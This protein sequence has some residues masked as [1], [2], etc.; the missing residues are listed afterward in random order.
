[1]KLIKYL[2]ILLFISIN[3]YSE[4]FIIHIVG[5]KETLWSISKK[6]NVP[7]DEIIK[8]NNLTDSSKLT[9][10]TQLKIPD[11]TS[12]PPVELIKETRTMDLTDDMTDKY[13]SYVFKK[14]DSV[15]QISRKY[16]I[17][18][19]ELMEL[20]NIKDAKNIKDGTEL[21]IEKISNDNQF[22][23]EKSSQIEFDTY[24][25]KE[26]ETLYAISR[27]FDITVDE[28][29]KIN[30]ITNV[31]KIKSGIVLKISKKISKVSVNEN[32][33]VN[34]E[35]VPAK[36]ITYTIKEKE[37]LWSMSKKFN[38]SVEKI[39]EIN[40]IKSTKSIKKGSVLKIPASVNYLDYNLP[41]DGMIKSFSS[42]HFKGIHIYTDEDNDKRNILAVN[43][44]NVS[45]VDNVPGFG[46][47][48]FIR[49]NDDYISTYSGFEVIYV[50]Q[51]DKVKINQLIGK[52]GSLSRHDKF[53][54][55]FS[56]Q[57]KGNSLE[58]DQNNKKFIKNFY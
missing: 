35:N 27:K 7:L 16:G 31:S 2:I 14:G 9:S 54:I 57:Y 37:T 4:D 53:G 44:G 21:K 41:A 51:G 5:E 3:I 48:I 39:C 25:I 49:H 52:A 23:I 42:M 18:L 33:P 19:N 34:K 22:K 11:K 1:M 15:W 20:N 32:I 12:K 45:Y 26:K 28:I 56:I 40:S 29:C 58:F 10:G 8:L 17:N 30:N 38:I 50:K 24:T 55:L 43:D 6:Y 46:L 47:T 36:F 13:Q